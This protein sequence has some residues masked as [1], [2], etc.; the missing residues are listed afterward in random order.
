MRSP[1]FSAATMRRALVGTAL[2]GLALSTLSVA[3]PSTATA[4]APSTTHAG[5]FADPAAVD[6]PSYRFWT[7]GGNLTAASAATQLEAMKA[8]GA[9]GV[10]FNQAGFGMPG[11]NAAAQSFGTPAWADALRSVYGS[12]AA[13]GLIA[14]VI[15]TPGWSAGIQGI[16]PDKPGT[17][18]KIA[19][20]RATLSAGAQFDAAVPAAAK[21][22][23]VTAA[24]LQAVVAYRCST[25]CSEATPVLIAKSA[26]DLTDQVS[27][28]HLTWTAPASPSGATWIIVSSW[29]MGTG[30]T[31]GLAGTPTPSY[32]VD[33]FSNDGFQAIKNFWDTKVLDT[34]LRAKLK[35]SGGSLFFDSL[36]LE[37]GTVPHWTADFLQEF[38]KR[39]GYSLVPYLAAVGVGT[40]TFDFAGDTGDRVR[41]D[42]KQTLSDL[43]RDYHLT[44]L[45]TWA[46]SLGLTLRGQAYASN[47]ESSLDMQEMATL[48]DVAEGED[49]SF[50]E[51]TDMSLTQN[52]SSDIWRALSS[53]SAQSGTGI[54]STECCAT[55]GGS[56]KIPR[57]NL[58]ADVNQQLVTGVN[59]FV[60]HGWGD[61]T[62][63]SAAA[64]PGYGLFGGAVPDMYG[65]HN[66]TWTDDTSIN[67]YVGRMS[68]ILRRG[69]LKDDVAIY[70]QGSGHSKSGAT[71]ELYFSDQSLADAGYTY[72]FM[73]HTLVAEKKAKVTGGRLLAG[74]LDYQAFVID[75]TPTVDSDTALDLT[76]AQ[77]VL[78]W[79]KAGLPIVVVG[80]TPDRTRGLAPGDDAALADALADLADQ[81]S[82]TYVKKQA[83]VLGAL[84]RAGVTPAASFSK[85]STLLNIRR[86]TADTNYYYLWN[87]DA[88]DTVTTTVELDGDG[89]PFEYDPWSGTVKQI[90]E[91]TRTRTGVR[92]NVSAQPGDG[93][94]LAVT[95]GNTETAAVKRSATTAV[96]TTA[97]SA[98]VDA[99]GQLT[100]RAAKAGTYRTVLS[101][102]KTVS[103]TIGAVAAIAQPTS[104]ALD[105]TSYTAGATID[106]TVKTPLA[107]IAVAAGGALPDWQHLTGLAAVSGTSTYT[108]TVNVPASVAASG[109][110]VLDLGSVLGTFRVSVNGQELPT[111]DL[112]DSHEVDLGGRLKA[113]ANTVEVHVATLLGNAKSNAG[114]AYGLVGPV[115]VTPYGSAAVKQVTAPVTALKVT[116]KPVITG[117]A[118]AGK[119]LR[120]KPG[121]WSPAAASYSYTWKRNGHVIAGARS[122]AYKVKKGDRG[123][124][125]T[126]TVT[127]SRPGY[128]SASATSAAKKIKRR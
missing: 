128:T 125:I 54:I 75:N 59:K 53:A 109:G 97:D 21:P 38:E 13:D 76:T 63:G 87:R 127:A 22:S 60:W 74:G 47:H 34:D 27:G 110:A 123:K 119:K 5:S 4:A 79:A 1:L 44:P 89:V 41:E 39:R 93:V 124:R 117:T 33:H 72:G 106:A 82:V 8:G 7:S 23:G 18:K 43:F 20:G 98:S 26:V 2:A 91:F 48:L 108:T 114:T 85:P 78:T 112:L 46:H 15:Y 67:D 122:A 86:Q 126:V 66:P 116:S 90:A 80:R 30:K 83:D 120:A 94:L 69:E 101:N 64:W 29:M 6:R 51:P 42:Y 62:V 58:L 92:V 35:A 102:G 118:K 12:A 25:D 28:G 73:N 57:Q 9:G 55:E 103:T 104:W 37:E 77:K 84:Q 40:P 107:P 111:V 52:Y 36:E 24:D 3:M 50:N 32:V 16:S 14:D 10:E 88:D 49:R 61:T 115:T 113:G 65:P 96:S 19:F 31:N 100:V 121:T 56:F 45:K 95:Q 11:Y 81:P 70:R 105:V 17:D 71:G 99:A 68:T